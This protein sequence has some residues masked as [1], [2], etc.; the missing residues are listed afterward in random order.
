MLVCRKI[1]I[2]DDEVNLLKTLGLILS[3]AGYDVIRA[4][5]ATTANRILQTTA[6]SLVFLDLRLPD[7]D[8]L[9]LLASIHCQYPDTSVIILTGYPTL[10]TEATARE[11]GARAYLKKPIDPT[12]I[13]HCVQEIFEGRL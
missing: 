1:L 2:V 11:K 4:K 8:G 13:I 7:A 10:E 6:C 5:D 9:D 3:K 12:Q